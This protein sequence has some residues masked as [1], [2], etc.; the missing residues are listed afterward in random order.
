MYLSLPAIQGST[1]RRLMVQASPGIKKDSI[2][3]TT[4]A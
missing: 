2:S 4:N 3:K 1:N